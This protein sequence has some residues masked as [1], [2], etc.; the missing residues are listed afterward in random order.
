MQ[1]EITFSDAGWDF[2]T[3]IWTI[4]EGLEY[5]RL[6]WEFEAP[7]LESEPDTTIGTS[8][9]I[10]WGPVADANDYLAECA[11]DANF[12][13][14]LYSSGWIGDTNYTFTGLEAGRR[15]WYSVKARR[16]CGVESEWSNVESSLQVT[17][18]EAVEA[19]LDANS[20]QNENM[21]NALLNKIDAAQAMIDDGQY[22]AALNKLQND[23]LAKMDGCAETGEP[24]KNDWLITCEAQNEVYPLIMET[25]EYV[26]ALME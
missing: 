19:A 24:D 23:I 18:G 12:V 16:A 22:Q 3:P 4:C 10:F 9:T 8:N 13:S 21:M 11:E 7:A 6:C 2:I 20:L 14:V 26:T 15:Y 1:T 5:P 25:I 17:L